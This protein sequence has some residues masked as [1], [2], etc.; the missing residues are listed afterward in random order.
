M[1]TT[2]ALEQR[3]TLKSLIWK[4]VDADEYVAQQRADWDR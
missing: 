2:V 4:S 3:T 1:K